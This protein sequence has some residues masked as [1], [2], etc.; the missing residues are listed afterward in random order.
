MAKD[1]LR[2][3]IKV[4]IDLLSDEDLTND[5]QGYLRLARALRYA[6]DDEN[7]LAVWSLIGPNA[8]IES[9]DTDRPDEVNGT[10]E[11]NISLANHDDKGSGSHRKRI[12][13]SS[14]EN[15]GKQDFPS[16][17]RQSSTLR[18]VLGPISFDGD[19]GSCSHSWIFADDIHVCK[20]CLDL[21][22]P[23]PCL[24][25]LRRDELEVKICDPR[26]EH[27]HVPV[28]D[29]DGARRRGPTQVRRGVN[30]RPVSEWISEIRRN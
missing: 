27:L 2:H 18:T 17:L 16:S 21:K 14:L 22:F 4:G 23:S 13:T 15:S 10:A 5:W 25:V 28:W 3:Q 30:V 26:H 29:K 9:E 7:A 20:D 12:K 11:R 1:C 6:G 24:G 8:F 19:G